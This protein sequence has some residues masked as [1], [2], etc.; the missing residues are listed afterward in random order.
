MIEEAKAVTS[1]PPQIPVVVSSRR[2]SFCAPDTGYPFVFDEE[3]PVS[4]L[5][6]KIEHTTRGTYD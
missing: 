5:L 3:S 2:H 6:E 4:F 1:R